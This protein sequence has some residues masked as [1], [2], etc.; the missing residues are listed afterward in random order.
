MTIKQ[1]CDIAHGLAVA[2]GF[3]D[4]VPSVDQRLMM[5][6]TE[7]AEAHEELRSGHSVTHTYTRADG[8]PEGFAYELADAVIRI[9]DL[10]GHLGIDLESAI[11]EK[12]KFNAT[13]PMKHGRAF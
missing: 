4:P 5:I 11:E 10:A 8:K 7:I 9:C 1:L 12:H 2:K 13:R 3:Y 6:V